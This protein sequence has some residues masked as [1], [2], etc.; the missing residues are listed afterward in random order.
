[1]SKAITLQMLSKTMSNTASAAK[2]RILCFY[3]FDLLN[4]LMEKN[5][6]N[7]ML[8]SKNVNT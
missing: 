6:E 4:N 7:T 8:M 5:R 2:C 3:H 1:M